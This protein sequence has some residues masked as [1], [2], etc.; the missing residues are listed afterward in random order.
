MIDLTTIT[1]IMAEE[2]GDGLQ[3]HAPVDR[4]GGHGVAEPVRVDAGDA[5]GTGDAAHYPA[6]D[7]PVQS[8]PVVGDQPLVP[9]DV[10]EVGRSPGG[11]Q[12]H[13]VR[14]QRNVPVVA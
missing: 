4:L 9:A 11:E 8:A 13:Q 6:D 3:P 7:V 2:G 1:H 14:V 5:G 10:I 12:F